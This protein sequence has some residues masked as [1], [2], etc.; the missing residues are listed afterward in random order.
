ME[1]IGVR[2]LR[3]HASRWLQRVRAGE[4]FQVTDRGR[5][6]ALLAPL[7]SASVWQR[8]VSSGEVT[9]A[10]GHVLDVDPLP[11]VSGSPSASDVLREMR[12]AERW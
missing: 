10:T 9:A 3:Q 7:P 1:S 4:S 12:D 11:A 5:P 8:L 2:E 6:V